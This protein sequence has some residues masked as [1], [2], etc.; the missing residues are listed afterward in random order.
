M[1]RTPY[2]TGFKLETA[3]RRIH[4]YA[5]LLA[6][7]GYITFKNQPS[8]SSDSSFTYSLGGGAEFNVLPSWKVRADFTEQHWNLDPQ[9]LN[10]MSFGVGVSYSIPFHRSGGW[11]H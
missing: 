2:L 3:I 8:Y 9:V 10:P 4:P 6:G 11:V 7:M 5:T 1:A